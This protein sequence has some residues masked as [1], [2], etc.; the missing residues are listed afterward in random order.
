MVR[1]GHSLSYESLLF[2]MLCNSCVLHFY[3]CLA[4]K[5]ILDR[6]VIKLSKKIWLAVAKR[7]CSDEVLH[8]TKIY[9]GSPAN[10]L[11]MINEK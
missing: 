3:L 9:D 4:L 6:S 7:K 8:E 5:V 10:S 1:E 11:A 2:I